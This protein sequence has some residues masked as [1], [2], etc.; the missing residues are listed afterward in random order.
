VSD[1]GLT[2]IDH[3]GSRDVGKLANPAEAF[4]NIVQGEKVISVAKYYS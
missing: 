4:Q 2:H 1:E 3:I